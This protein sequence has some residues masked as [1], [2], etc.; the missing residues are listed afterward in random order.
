MRP[1]FNVEIL[2]VAELHAHKRNYREHPDD[3]IKHLQESLKTFGVYRNIVVAKDNTILAGHGVVSAAKK[4][5]IKRIPVFRLNVGANDRRA[6]KLLVADNEIEH[7]AEQSDRQLADLLKELKETD[8]L[9][10]TGFD[11]M[12]VANFLMTTRAESEIATIDEAAH[13][14]GMPEYVGEKRF[15]F[16]IVSFRSDKARQAFAR[17]LKIEITAKTKS[18]WYP[19]EQRADVM[20]KE[21]VQR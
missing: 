13:W 7:L 11:E 8:D 16:L 17:L 15:P 2:D 14:I 9:L 1:K 18:I 6:I 10:G 3:Q 12:M 4:S 21:F 19:P 20:T 5:G